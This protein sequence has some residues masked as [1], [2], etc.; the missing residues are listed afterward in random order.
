MP[1]RLRS[2]RA[3]TAGAFVLVALAG[4]TFLA[5]RAPPPPPVPSFTSDPST[6]QGEAERAVLRLPA[7]YR[8][9]SAAYRSYLRGLTLR[10][11]FKFMASR[12]TLAALVDREPLYVPGIYGL[13]H[14]YIFLALNGLTEPGE[15]WPKVDALARR[16]V[17]LD[18]S[19]A[20]AWLALAAEEM[21]E[22]LDLARADTLIARARR[23][24]SLDPDAAG[25]RSTWFRFHGRMD[26]AVAYAQR[27]HRLDPL[28]VFFD[29]QVGKQLFFARRYEESRQVYARLL[30]EDPG[31]SR[32]YTD[33]VELYRA[34]GQPRE[35]VEWLRRA[36]AA[37][38][39]TAGAA[40][41]PPP[42]SDDE[43]WALLAAD[44]RRTL[45]D[46]ERG[47]RAG[48][49]VR[50]SRFAVTHAILRDTSATFRW[51]DA[52]TTQRDSYLAQ[53]RVD[54]V[55]D[56]L[57]TDARYAAW[58]RRSGLPPLAARAP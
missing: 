54:P 48:K 27:A 13:A 29:R 43:A 23:L 11:Q 31:W 56:F 49:P 46:L 42:A 24:D 7:R 12:D 53:V 33:A 47:V 22:H 32:G 50:A 30:A 41:L 18:S 19:A 5:G 45:A 14:T 17:A 9:D 52:M 37:A 1:V 25:M 16:A 51:L 2:L 20:K 44:A 38:G 28:S 3:V 21:F 57:R 34:M 8:A 58:E 55:F 39:D 35:A 40:L 26:S 6:P 4:A 10:F 36:R 15:T